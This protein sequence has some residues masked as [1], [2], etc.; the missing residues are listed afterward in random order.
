MKV[1]MGYQGH[2]RVGGVPGARESRWG[3]RGTGGRRPVAACLSQGWGLK[4]GV[5]WFGWW[6]RFLE[7]H[8]G[9]HVVGPGA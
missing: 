1:W 3:T 5:Q 9:N 4:F 7:P 6:A 8:M 2:E